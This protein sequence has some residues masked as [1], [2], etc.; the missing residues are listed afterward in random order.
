MDEVDYQDIVDS[1]AFFLNNPHPTDGHRNSF[2]RSSGIIREYENIGE[3]ILNDQEPHHDWIV[4]RGTSENFHKAAVKF[5]SRLFNHSDNPIDQQFSSYFS[6]EVENGQFG[7]GVAEFLKFLELKIMDQLVKSSQSLNENGDI[8]FASYLYCQNLISQPRP[9]FVNTLTQLFHHFNTNVENEI[10]INSFKWN[11]DIKKVI[12]SVIDHIRKVF[13][14]HEVL[15]DFLTLLPQLNADSYSRSIYN[16]KNKNDYQLL[17]FTIMMLRFPSLSL[18]NTS[19]TRFQNFNYVLPVLFPTGLQTRS[20]NM[21]INPVKLQSVYYF[22]PKYNR[23]FGQWPRSLRLKDDPQSVS[24][25]KNINHNISLLRNFIVY[26]Q[27]SNDIIQNGGKLH[28]ESF[29]TNQAQNLYRIVRQENPYEL[30]SIVDQYTRLYVSMTVYS[31]ENDTLFHIPWVLEAPFDSEIPYDVSQFCDEWDR[32]LGQTPSGQAVSENSQA[33]T[34][35]YFHFN[36]FRDPL[37][38]PIIPEGINNNMIASDDEVEIP[39]PPPPRKRG[40]FIGPRLPPKRSERIRNRQMGANFNILGGASYDSDFQTH[41]FLKK[42]MVNKFQFSPALFET[43]ETHLQMCIVLSV[44]KAQL[45]VLSFENGNCKNLLVSNTTNQKLKCDPYRIES[46]NDYS[47]Y[48]T[49][50]EIVNLPK[51]FPFLEFHK[52]KWYIRL[53]DGTKWVKETSINGNKYYDGAKSKKEIILW[54]LVA[55]EILF[56]MQ[57]KY[58]KWINY[59]HVGEFCQA[60]AD[61]FGVCISVYNIELRAKRIQI[62][63]PFNMSPKEIVQTQQ[64]CAFISIVYDVG[65]FHAIT[66][67]PAFITT[68]TRKDTLRFHNFCPVCESTQSN[69]LRKNRTDAFVH[70]SDCFMNKDWV[71]QYYEEKDYQLLTEKSVTKQEIKKNKFGHTWKAHT[72]KKCFQIFQSEIEYVKH[73]CYVY[74]KKIQRNPD[75]KLWVFDLE[76]SQKTDITGKLIHKCNCVYL[77]KIYCNN[78]DEEKGYHFQNETDLILFLLENDQF[79]DTIIFAHNGG[80]YDCY[81]LVRICQRLEIKYE[82]IP[83][84]TSPNKYL[85]LKLVEKNICFKDFMRFVPQSLKAIAQSFNIAMGKGDFPHRFNNGENDQYIGRIPPIDTP[86]DYWSLNSFKAEKTKNEFI[87]WYV[88]QEL[89]YCGCA[90][91]CFCN[92][93]K[94]DFQTEI[95]KYCLLDTVVLAEVIKAFRNVILN[96]QDHNISKDDR[97]TNLDCDIRG[98]DITTFLTIPQVSKEIFLNMFNNWDSDNHDFKGLTTFSIHPRGSYA[99]QAG[100]WVYLVAKERNWDLNKLIYIGN[101]IRDY[102]DFDTEKCYDGYYPETNTLLFYLKCDYFGCPH[103]CYEYF[104]TNE[105]LPS[106]GININD[107]RSAFL[108]E[109]KFLKQKY[110]EVIGIWECQFAPSLPEIDPFL[111][112]CFGEDNSRLTPE[113]SFFGGRTEVFMMVADAEKKKCPIKYLDFGSLYPSC[114]AFHELPYGQPE[115]ILGFNIDKN[116]FNKNHEDRYY[117]YVHCYVVCPKNCM[118]GLLPKRCPDTGRLFFPVTDMSGYWST[119]ELYLA[120]E[121]GYVVTEIYE[122]YHWGIR[123]RSNIHLKEFVA[124]FFRKKQQA[125]GWKKMGATSENPTEEEKKT[126]CDEVY[127][128]MRKL[129]KIVPEEVAVDKCMEAVMKLIMNSLWGKMA[130]ATAKTVTEIVYST[131]LMLSIWNDNQIDQKSIKMIEI[132]PNVFQVTYKIKEEFCDPPTFVNKFWA[133]M[134]TV[135]G[136]NNLHEQILKIG[137]EDVIYTDTDSIIH[138]HDPIKCQGLI[139]R[140]IGNLC[141]EYPNDIIKRVYCIAPKFYSILLAKDENDPG[142]EKLRAKGVQLTLENMKKINY[143]SMKPLI[144]SIVKGINR[145]KAEKIEVDNFQIFA[146]TT[147]VNL[148][149]LDVQS[150]YNKKEVRSIITKRYVEVEENFN[151][152]EFERSQRDCIRTYPFG[153]EN[154]Y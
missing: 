8:E 18:D 102:H 56:H 93:K 59:N 124:F 54:Q 101:S 20:F 98:L 12:N 30:Q 91:D 141:D 84:P 81:F 120:M 63:S 99:W 114:Y 122:M 143:N 110:T 71:L 135:H 9:E 145:K 13:N 41:L 61:M 148:E 6:N 96:L 129:C 139:K 4:G 67:Y 89:I 46:F 66:S 57:I 152:E 16:L 136:R 116:R 87:A 153:Y 52:G 55:E 24:Y 134:V 95:K 127:L 45:M 15:S 112:K 147:N 146:N 29:M 39:P 60:F 50:E 86:E 121:N 103:C 125:G 27:L 48:L 113:N 7:L 43:P 104:T 92:K 10:E 109:M 47:I 14:G 32:V 53:F 118:V 149:F 22:I 17:L 31:N 42:T 138:Y 77:R 37:I 35:F 94:W 79:E 2:L 126:I 133:A 107:V 73:R 151:W 150:R 142:K 78:E 140:G 144:G 34:E 80:S 11:G 3:D 97:P 40:R 28:F 90:N 33:S 137:P 26:T 119:E 74:K 108:D 123:E 58:K 62:F 69:G 38:N 131:Q 72:C 117:G 83:S 1:R 132:S 111:K 88:S 154:N 68:E 64:R 70:Y 19:L 36:F 49:A 65:H 130:Q 51:Y 21:K 128:E 25:V 100:L 82:Y 115:H 5:G 23:V 105:I 106:R 44:I 76:C 85:M 75:D